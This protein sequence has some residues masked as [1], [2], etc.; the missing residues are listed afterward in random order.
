MEN[1]ERSLPMW[2]FL[3]KNQSCQPFSLP[4]QTPNKISRKMPFI[5]IVSPFGYQFGC[6]SLQSTAYLRRLRM[7]VFCEIFYFKHLRNEMG[8][9][10]GTL[11]DVNLFPVKVFLLP[12][13][14][15][16]NRNR[17]F[18]RCC[19]CVAKEVRISTFGLYLSAISLLPI[20]TPNHSVSNKTICSRLLCTCHHACVG[21]FKMTNIKSSENENANAY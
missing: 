20:T 14:N 9:S 18:A 15:W 2:K 1:C 12:Q 16:S 7:C 6:E 4:P 17:F 21:G 13:P 10:E 5:K 11:S 3:P 8:N 19:L